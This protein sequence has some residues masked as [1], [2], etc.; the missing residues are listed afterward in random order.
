MA[1]T[2]RC[3]EMMKPFLAFALALSASGCM[4]T[5]KHKAIVA[6]YRVALEHQSLMCSDSV[7]WLKAERDTYAEDAARL[8]GL[9]KTQIVNNEE[10]L[11]AARE[12]KVKAAI[13][14]REKILSERAGDGR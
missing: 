13:K 12:G 4:S 14:K 5:K 11:Q 2:H 1:W 6:Q 3:V 7:R 8:Q 9:L 10:I